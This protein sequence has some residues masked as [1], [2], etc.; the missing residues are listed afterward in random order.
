MSV[1]TYQHHEQEIIEPPKGVPQG[2]TTLVP[3]S[4]TGQLE[5]IQKQ[6][7]E[8]KN[9]N[10]IEHVAQAVGVDMKTFQ[11]Q[12]KDYLVAIQTS[13]RRMT[14]ENDKENIAN[15]LMTEEIFT[16]GDMLR[17]DFYKNLLKIT[18]YENNKEQNI[19]D[20]VEWLFLNVIAPDI[21]KTEQT[22]VSHRIFQNEAFIRDFVSTYENL[23]ASSQEIYCNLLEFFSKRIDFELSRSQHQNQPQTALT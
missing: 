2:T 20:L 12:M 15:F 7:D 5:D 18:Q 14:T 8:L 9:Q 3:F 21:Q 13:A 1:E 23:G 19:K 17:E 22:Y 16:M 11:E 10:H 4:I 6:L